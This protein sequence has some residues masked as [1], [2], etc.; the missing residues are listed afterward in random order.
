MWT[1]YPNLSNPERSYSYYAFIVQN[2]TLVSSAEKN[3]G[4]VTA[5][6]IDA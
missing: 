3:V 1:V 2:R 6:R 4:V 5:I